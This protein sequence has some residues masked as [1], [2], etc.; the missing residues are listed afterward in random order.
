[1]RKSEIV[2]HD[3]GANT[4]LS[5]ATSMKRIRS[6]H[7][8]LRTVIIGNFGVTTDIINPL[9][10]STGTWYDFFSGDSIFVSNPTEEIVLKPGQFHIY[11]DRKLE[12]PPDDIINSIDTDQTVV[13]KYS[14]SQNFPNPFNPST[15][16]KFE[17]AKSSLVQIK[18]Y[19]II[20]Q[21]VKELVNNKLAAGRYEILWNGKNQHGISVGS[22]VFIYEIQAQ[23]AGKNVFR[24]SRKMVLIR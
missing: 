24:Q 5:V 20:G 12:S 2:F 7:Y 15:T 21:E 14:L 23:S 3:P 10:Y 4:E 6:A 1:L 11:T 13:R 16:I 9:F 8:N 19:N 17:L 18:I 22:G